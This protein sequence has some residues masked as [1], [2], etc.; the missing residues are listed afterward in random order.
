MDLSPTLVIP[1]PS[2]LTIQNHDRWNRDEKQHGN[3]IP[4]PLAEGHTVSHPCVPSIA[5]ECPSSVVSR[6]VGSMGFQCAW[7][8]IILTFETG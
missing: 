6:K 8:L 2:D 5:G 1:L 3:L 7:L 4:H